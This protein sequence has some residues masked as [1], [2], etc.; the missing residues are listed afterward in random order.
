MMLSIW[1]NFNKYKKKLNI[2]VD[3]LRKNYGALDE[4]WKEEYIIIVFLECSQCS[5][6]FYTI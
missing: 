3:Q 5:S 2:E 1:K 4:F 6:E